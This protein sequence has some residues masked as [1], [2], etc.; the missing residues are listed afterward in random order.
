MT[1]NKGIRRRILIYLYPARNP[2]YQDIID[3]FPRAR[4]QA[5]W[6]IILA[7]GWREAREL[8]DA[9]RAGDTARI[10]RWRQQFPAARS[11]QETVIAGELPILDRTNC[12][13]PKV[14]ISIYLKPT[15]VVHQQILAW[16]DQ[17]PTPELRQQFGRLAL[18][19]GAA[20][21]DVDAL[22][23]AVR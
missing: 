16:Y 1:H 9:Y 22:V 13:K 8:I 11:R 19:I 17:I 18:V 14:R 4:A 15:N 5:M 23:A 2:L 7:L 21:P 12:S 3:R 6:H 10:E 20:H